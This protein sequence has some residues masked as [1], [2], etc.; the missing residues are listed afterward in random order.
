MLG[1]FAEDYPDQVRKSAM[2]A[3]SCK[4]LSALVQPFDLSNRRLHRTD[5]LDQCGRGVGSSA[6]STRS[7]P[8]T[9]HLNET[10][11]Q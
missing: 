2:L 10:V 5:L 8:P 4:E 7:P 11:Q 6:Y 3:E 1:R 9:V